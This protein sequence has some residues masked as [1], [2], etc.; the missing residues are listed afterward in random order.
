MTSR[1]GRFNPGDIEMLKNFYGLDIRCFGRAA[2]YKGR[3]S[4][5]GR[6][7]LVGEW[8]GREYKDYLAE[9]IAKKETPK[10]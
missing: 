3:G 10:C 8:F 7:C 4:A 9:R 1:R 6:W 5:P 2:G